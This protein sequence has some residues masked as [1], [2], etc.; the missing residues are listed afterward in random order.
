MVINAT[1]NVFLYWIWTVE[2]GVA[3]CWLGVMLR[4]NTVCIAYLLLAVLNDGRFIQCRVTR[5]VDV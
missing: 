2:V 3:R 4:G 5:W 1:F